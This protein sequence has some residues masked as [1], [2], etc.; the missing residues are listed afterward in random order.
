MGQDPF[1]VLKIG[2]SGELVSNVPP[3]VACPTESLN[4]HIQ[5][6]ER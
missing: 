4:S 6:S 5:N 2:I 3:V 1:D